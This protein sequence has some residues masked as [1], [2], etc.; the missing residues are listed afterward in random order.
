MEKVLTIIKNKG[1][2]STTVYTEDKK[3]KFIQLHS[4]L[5]RKPFLIK[6]DE[7]FTINFDYADHT[8]IQT[9]PDYRSFRQREYLAGVDLDTTVCRSA[10]NL[11]VKNGDT[12][13][14]Y[15]LDVNVKEELEVESIPSDDEAQSTDSDVKIDDFPVQ[16]IY[17][18]YDIGEFIKQ[19]GSFEH[20]VLESY[21]SIVDAEE[22]MNEQSVEKLLNL[23]DQQK[24][25]LKERIYKLHLD[26]YNI[27]R[28]ITKTGNNLQRVYELRSR[29]THEK[30]RVRFK[31]DRL[32]AETEENIDSLNEKLRET[33]N[34]ASQ[35]LDRYFGY[36]DKFNAF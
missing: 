26:A 4:D 17:P 32:V 36:V 25:L 15:I 23:F 27:R 11:C 34:D 5:Q 20:V 3:V 13:T 10:S 22:K 7:K 1:Y 19:I 28:D 29:S 18:L 16:D 24:V 33:R 14:C 30:D 6:V 31:L 12:I 35:L 21:Q 9:E 2:T 8:I